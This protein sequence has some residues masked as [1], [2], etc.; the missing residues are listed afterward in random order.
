MLQAILFIQTSVDQLK[1]YLPIICSNNLV[2]S[3]EKQN[4][5][6]KLLRSIES[7]LLGDTAVSDL[8][9]DQFNL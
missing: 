2:T 7:F 6:L 5:I 8:E 4:T 9:D 3:R 1:K